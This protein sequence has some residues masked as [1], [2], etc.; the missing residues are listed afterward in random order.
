MGQTKTWRR[1]SDA[2]AGGETR[3]RELLMMLTPWRTDYV[4]V[5]VG[6]SGT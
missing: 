5:V 1:L 2:R 6:L 4:C 3:L